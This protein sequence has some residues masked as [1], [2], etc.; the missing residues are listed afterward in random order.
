MGICALALGWLAAVL[1]PGETPIGPAAVLG[2]AGGLAVL[3]ALCGLT[4]A[5]GT[6][7]GTGNGRRCRYGRRPSAAPA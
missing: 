5:G 3:A 2:S 1:S 4:I 6:L 7:H